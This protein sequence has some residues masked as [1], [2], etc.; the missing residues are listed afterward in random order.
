MF[1]AVQDRS[2]VHAVNFGRYSLG[3]TE[4][5]AFRNHVLLGFLRVAGEHAE[6]RAVIGDQC[7]AVGLVHW[8]LN[9]EPAVGRRSVACI[10]PHLQ[11]QAAVGSDHDVAVSG[12]GVVDDGGQVTSDEHVALCHA[13]DFAPGSTQLTH[14]AVAVLRTGSRAREV[15]GVADSSDLL[16]V[17]DGDFD[18]ASA[19]GAGGRNQLYQQT[20]RLGGVQWVDGSVRVEHEL[21]RTGSRRPRS[22]RSWQD[23][24][25]TDGFQVGE[26]CGSNCGKT[27]QFRLGVDFTSHVV[28]LR[29]CRNKP[30][31]GNRNVGQCWI[32][33]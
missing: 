13:R 33:R 10:F 20:P 28:F 30:T 11:G 29:L 24:G 27:L 4:Y 7:G 2:A 12:T 31:K 25:H 8:G 1:L 3:W 21:A 15:G 19:W 26:Q 16:W 22:A 18:R 5:V 23:L 14:N 17:G 6:D 32:N 9:H